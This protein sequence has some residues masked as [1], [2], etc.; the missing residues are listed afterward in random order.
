MASKQTNSRKE[1]QLEIKNFHVIV[2]KKNCPMQGKCRM[3]N[4]LYKC[5]AST[6]TKPQRG[7]I[8]I[9]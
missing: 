7:Y 3:K 2:D 4:I 8:G 5:I 9:S 1:S 6:P